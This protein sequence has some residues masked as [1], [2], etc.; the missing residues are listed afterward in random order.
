MKAIFK[1]VISEGETRPANWT[2]GLRQGKRK[3]SDGR[4]GG[5]PE[6]SPELC[7]L[8]EEEHRTG[9]RGQAKGIWGSA[10]L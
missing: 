1:Y 3:G 8:F 10:D 6:E 2:V 4:E 9:L 5:G 7:W